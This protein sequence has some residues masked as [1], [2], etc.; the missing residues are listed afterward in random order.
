MERTLPSCRQACRL[1]GTNDKQNNCTCAC[2]QA[3]FDSFTSLCLSNQCVLGAEP[4]SE[5]CASDTLLQVSSTCPQMTLSALIELTISL[6]AFFF[7]SL[8]AAYLG[9]TSTQIPQVNDKALHFTTFFLLALTFYWIFDTSRRRVL[10]LTLLIVTGMLGIGSEFLQS[11]LPN[12]R[13]FDALD[14]AA[15]VVGSL[16]AS[17][18]CTLYHR[19]MLERK[20][21]RKGYGVVPQEGA[22]DVELGPQESG[23][24]NA[25]EDDE[26]WDDMGA[27]E[28][29]GHSDGDGRM[30]PSSGGGGDES[31]T[32]K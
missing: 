17:G 13:K 18:L 2:L 24:V 21:R 25:H 15:N 22:E 27:G 32:K 6:G 16:A 4:D 19:R 30:T 31:D 11:F 10:N 26:P 23:V 28:D 8:L 12:G 20:R 14:I 9:L 5:P 7:L 1:T 29:S 3:I